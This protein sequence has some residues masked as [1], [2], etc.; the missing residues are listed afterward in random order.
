VLASLIFILF[1][2]SDWLLLRVLPH[3]QLSFAP[4]VGLPLAASLL[5]RSAVFAA[6][7]GALLLARRRRQAASG[8]QHGRSAVLFFVFLNLGFSLV[9]VDAYVMEPLLV[10][11]TELALEFDQ[12]DP[13]KPPVRLVHLTDTH[14][15]RTGYREMD[16]IREVN[17]L[18]PDLIV[19]TGDYLNLSYL[20]DPAA[21]KHLRYFIAQ[22][23]APYGIYAVRG[24]VEP[25][26][27]AMAELIR[28][29]GI[30]WLEQEA[31]TVEVRG[32]SLTLAGVAC[33]HD[34]ELDAAR[35]AQAL[36]VVPP[37]DLTVLLYHSP[38]LILEASARQVDL[39][40]AGHTHGGQIRLP[41]LGP[42][43][44]YSRYGRRYAS[45]L[46]Q[47]G[48]TTMY[49]SRGLGFEGGSLPR[50]RFLCRPE[51]VSI[52]LAAAGP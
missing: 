13:A 26:P 24:T 31:I 33:S 15:E 40:L 23:E 48:D 1:C 5:V 17:A 45:G 25:V 37:A 36:D 47:E 21:A 27:G 35:L 52:E 14:I 20:H 51:I 39:V 3:L 34:Q 30:V 42:V 4:T 43:V 44:T 32:Q 50:A 18:Q 8:T 19:L 46:F 38:D 12:L 16:V 49:V 11:T 9:Q 6:L 10:E 28:D 2:L 7:S 41:V 22:L 29:T